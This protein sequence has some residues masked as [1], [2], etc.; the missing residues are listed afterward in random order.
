MLQQADAFLAENLAREPCLVEPDIL[1]HGGK[2]LLY[3]FAG[4]GKSIIAM[5]LGLDISNGRPWLGHFETRQGPVVYLQCELPR[6]KFRDRLRDMAPP[7][8]DLAQFWVYTSLT[9]KIHPNDPEFRDFVKEVTA[10]K[11]VLFIVDPQYKVLVGDENS[12]KDIQVLYDLLDRLIQDTGTA[13]LLIDNRRKSRQDAEGWATDFGLGEL[14]GSQRKQGWM[15]AIVRLSKARGGHSLAFEKTRYGDAPESVQLTLGDEPLGFQVG[16][17][18]AVMEALLGELQKG[19]VLMADLKR[20]LLLLKFS[21]ITIRRALDDA[22]RDKLVE[23]KPLEHD[24]RQKEVR[25]SG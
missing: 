6:G 17:R 21:D 3:G 24:K 14:S 12:A 11:P 1:P 16:G 4:I 20:R 13:L 9:M 25:L 8:T 18:A 5:Q 2:A 15:D 10:I 23:S 22:E 19:P 7:Y